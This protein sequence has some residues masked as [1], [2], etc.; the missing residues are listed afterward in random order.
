MYTTSM[1][2]SWTDIILIAFAR[3]VRH[4]GLT[5]S[6]G[7]VVLL[8]S[9]T[10]G[11]SWMYLLQ[12]KKQIRADD[13][14]A[15]LQS[16]P[17]PMEVASAPPPPQIPS[18]PQSADSLTLL[19]KIK[20]LTKANGLA[21]SQAEYRFTPITSDSL[22]TLEISTSLKGPYLSLRTVLVELLDMEPALGLRELTLS[23]PNGDSSD[24]EAKIRWVVFLVDGWPE[25]PKEARHD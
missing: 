5:G 21:W 20:K 18:L 9:A 7:L 15:K 2:P 22:A 3:L 16:A 25:R 12:N 11:V 23:R 10:Y 13:E 6:V 8:V 17:A 14:P 4:V 1:Q 19:K 24:V